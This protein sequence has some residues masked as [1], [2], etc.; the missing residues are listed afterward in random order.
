MITGGARGIGRAYT[1]AFLAAGAKVVSTDRS[2]SGT[3]PIDP[4]PDGKL[5]LPPTWT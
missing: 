4:G 1:L 2:W 5:A 3:E